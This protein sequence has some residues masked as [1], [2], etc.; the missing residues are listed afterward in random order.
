MTL[1]KSLYTT[2]IQCS[3][4]LWLKKYKSEVLAPNDESSEIRFKTG[5]TVGEL[6][7][8]LFPN[9]V[10]VDFNPNLEQMVKET[11]KLLD[12]GVAV[13]YEA[14]FIFENTLVI[15]DIFEINSNG[16]S[17]YEVKSSTSLKEIYLHDVSIQYYTLEN[18]G[19]K[20]KSANVVYLNSNYIRGDEL[21]IK[22]LFVIED[23]TE[24][25]KLLQEAVP[26][27][28]QIFQT[29]LAD[30][31]TEPNIDI[32]KHCKNPYECLALDYCWK[33][34]RDIPDY[35]IFN[36]FNLGSKKQVELYFQGIVDVDD[37][38]DSFE[39]TVNQ[40]AAV[41][42]Y[43]SKQTYIDK[44]SIK[45]FLKT[46]TYPIYHLDFETFQQAIPEFKGLSPYEQIPFQ[47][48]LHIEYEDGRLEHKE[49]LANDEIDPR[50]E[51]AL[52][53]CE[54]IP[55][56]TTV[57]A[58][59]MSFEKGVIKR[60]ALLFDDLSEHLLAI[61]ENM[62]DLMIPF[63]KKWYVIPSMNGSYSI[64]YVLPSLVPEFE[65]AYKEL[66]GVQNG[67]QAMNAF[68]KLSSLDNKEKQKLRNSLLEYCKLDTLAMVKILKE[69]KKEVNNI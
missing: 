45:E 36:I 22:E 32:G 7:C 44:T 28:L 62:Q 31:E 21:D 50:Y 67:S 46:L 12:N 20:I 2:G 10:K 42:N 25:I 38:P 56:D 68:S 24:T 66:D 34:Q 4:A 41:D 26:T 5:H 3:K 48:S 19:Y 37:I 47:Y 63:Q 53:L 58:Y 29:Y 52:R 11:K 16:V 61:N 33:V 1:S 51:L 39:M 35:S 18:L 65:K 54:D 14:A 27:N 57:L 13:I 8:D 69:L 60:L 49:F 17:I 40:K 55:K 6:A 30:K 59:N 23:V 9:G 64:K 43:K 15:V